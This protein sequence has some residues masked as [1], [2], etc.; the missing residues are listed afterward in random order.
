MKYAQIINLI[1]CFHSNSFITTITKDKNRIINVK[2]VNLKQLFAFFFF[3]LDNSKIVKASEGTN[4]Q[5]HD[6]DMQFGTIN[7]KN[8]IFHKCGVVRNNIAY[9]RCASKRKF[10]CKA[11]IKVDKNEMITANDVPHNHVPKIP[12]PISSFVR[13]KLIYGGNSFYKHTETERK[14]HWRCSSFRL[15]QCIVRLHTDNSGNIQLIRGTHNHGNNS[16]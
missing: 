8:Y 14:T 5:Y 10:G 6:I 13:K 4:V 9:Y 2:A 3:F 7:Y 1:I 11:T 16:A 12:N 15:T